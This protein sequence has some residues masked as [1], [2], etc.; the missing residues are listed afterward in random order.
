MSGQKFRSYFEK[1]SNLKSLDCEAW[2]QYLAITVLSPVS[3]IV[4]HIPM[5]LYGAI[6][7]LETTKASQDFC[8]LDAPIIGHDII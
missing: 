8:R 4:L 7:R 6:S 2:M 1:W 5:L 3:I